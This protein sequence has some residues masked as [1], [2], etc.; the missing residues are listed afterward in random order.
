MAMT[1]AR[2]RQYAAIIGAIGLTAIALFSWNYVKLQAPLSRAIES[3][4]RNLGIEA[5]AHYG[6]YV[7]PR[8]LVFDLKMLD[9][10]KSPT[11]V[12]RVLLQFAAEV[13]DEEFQ[14]IQLAHRGT[15]KFVVHGEYFRRLGMEYGAQN[16]VYTMRTFP[17][18][19]L[20]PNG[21]QAYQ[22]WE[23]GWVGVATKQIED[24]N[25]FHQK[26]YILDLQDVQ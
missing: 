24:F 4:H 13:Q 26:W 2:T 10:E 3:D 16:P 23:G 9:Q 19:L 1:T 7:N 14:V 12:F 17:E 11:D 25:D 5:R 21:D 15:T 22:R 20:L 6:G 18:K 8:V